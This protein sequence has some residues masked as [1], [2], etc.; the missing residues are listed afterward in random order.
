MNRSQWLIFLCLNSIE[1]TFPSKAELTLQK[2]EGKIGFVY[3]YDC[4]GWG[5]VLYMDNINQHFLLTHPRCQ[6]CL[7][8]RRLCLCQRHYRNLTEPR[9]WVNKPGTV[10]LRVHLNVC[11]CACIHL[12]SRAE[13]PV[14]H[15][16]LQ[17]SNGEDRQN[18]LNQQA[19]LHPQPGKD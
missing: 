6:L 17:S 5:G 2:Q 10:W 15:N 14:A 8:S 13:L 3:L 1:K 16:M 7:H 11:L 9:D 12:C 18:R 19:A 4:G